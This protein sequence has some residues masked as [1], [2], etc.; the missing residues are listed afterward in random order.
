MQY[1]YMQK[2]KFF[3]WVFALHYSIYVCSTNIQHFLIRIL[4]RIWPKCVNKILF[5]L[6]RLLSIDSHNFIFKNKTNS[7]LNHMSHVQ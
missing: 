6:S 2:K 4:D 5:M 3:S 7:L 1:L